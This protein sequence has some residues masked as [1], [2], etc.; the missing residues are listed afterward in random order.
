M[1]MCVVRY[2]IVF[3]PVAHLTEGKIYVPSV[4]PVSAPAIAHFVVADVMAG[5]VSDA[6]YLHT[7]VDVWWLGWRW[8]EKTRKRTYEG[9]KTTGRKGKEM[10]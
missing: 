6:H 5:V 10:V 3:S 4:P 9:E 1:K 2:D 8:E 7:V